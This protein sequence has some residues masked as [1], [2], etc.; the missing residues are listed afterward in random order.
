MIPVRVP[1]KIKVT[2]MN[3]AVLTSIEQPRS[4]PLST[5]LRM[6]L[7]RSEGALFRSYISVTPPVK[8]SK[9]SH[10]LPPDRAS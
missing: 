7:K 4:D 9:P 5:A 3:V 6:M 10:V 8:S 1:G 2:I